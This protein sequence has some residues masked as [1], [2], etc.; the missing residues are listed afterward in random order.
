MLDA[1]LLNQVPGNNLQK[2][3]KLFDRAL[4]IWHHKKSKIR[5]HDKILK[6]GLIFNF[7]LKMTKMKF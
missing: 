5:W 4:F 2:S 3:C 1:E 6:C 7:I